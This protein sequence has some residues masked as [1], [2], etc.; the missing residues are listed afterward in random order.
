MKILQISHN[1]RIV[2]GSDAVFF[3]TSEL[4][5]NAGHEV[6]PFCID[7]PDNRPTSWSKYFPKA[8]DTKSTPIRDGLRYFYNSEAHRQLN[9]LLDQIGPVDVAHLHIYHGKQTPAIL[10]VLRKRGIPIVHTLHEYKMACPVYSMLRHGQPCDKCISGS[11]LNSIRHGCKDG[12][13]LKTM[14]MVAEKTTARLLGDVRLVDRFIC[15]SEFQHR[16]MLRAG[17]PPD[18]LFTLHNFVEPGEKPASGHDGYF[19][20]FGR[21]ETLKGIATMIEA[22]KRSGHRLLIAGDGNWRQDMESLISRVENIEY[23]GFQSGSE[24]NQLIRRAQGV[25][26]PSECYEN[27]PMSLLEAKACGRPV[28]GAD[29]G[30][31]PELIQDGIDGI[32]F[33]A[34]NTGA[35]IAAIETVANGNH[36]ILATNA[37]RDAETRFSAQVH[38]K[39]LLEHYSC[40]IEQSRQPA[41]HPA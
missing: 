11:D 36:S 8:A 23:L 16:V 5:G 29:T 40:V 6:V 22:F 28:I 19:L 21:I 14:V 18:R 10:S 9:R 27:C 3:A 20:Y 35:L 39:F 31:I 30:G 15:V 26:V 12:S 2:G 4:L 17:L 33:E 38:L 41:L 24:L 7:H 34:G 25:V 32:L 37:R 1:Y 13:R